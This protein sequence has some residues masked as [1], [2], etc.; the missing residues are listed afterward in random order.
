M[1]NVSSYTTSLIE[2]YTKNK[3]HM[4]LTVGVL[5]KGEK[6]VHVYGVNGE[7]LEEVIYH[8][9]IGSITKTF[10]AALLAKYVSDGIVSLDDSIDRYIELPSTG[11]YPSLRSLATHTSGYSALLPFTIGSYVGTIFKVL[12]GTLAGNPLAGRIDETRLIE[13]I[14]T[15]KRK[16]KEYTY[17]Y[18]NFGISV[19]GYILG[20][21]SGK[22][23]WEMMN[24]FIANDLHLLHT[25]LGILPNNIHGFNRKDEDCGNWEWDHNEPFAAAGGLSSTVEDLLAYAELNMSRDNEYFGLCRIKHAK[26]NRNFDMGLGWEL[27]KGTNL[28]YKDGG[29]G[30][31][32]S[33]IGFDQTKHVAAV[34]MA[35][36]TTP[37][38]AKIGQSLLQDI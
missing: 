8:Y 14:Q 15:T 25:R 26:G 32:T 33:F 12:N 9:E 19:L 38:I 16:Q 10:T 34:V 28:I 1:F 11:N 35:N 7:R 18:S 27:Q 20:N 23:Y 21:I 29:A 31:L 37:A 5:S 4:K 22:G 24:D 6:F 3:K 36:Y 30:A 2:K 13:I 17:S